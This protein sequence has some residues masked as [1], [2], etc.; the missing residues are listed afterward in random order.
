MSAPQVI[1]HGTLTG[2]TSRK[3]RCELC[4]AASAAWRRNVTR[5]SAYGR[6]Q[7]YVDAEPVR[8]WVRELMAFGIGWRRIANLAG[9]ASSAV[10]YLLYGDSDK[11]YPPARRLRPDTA[12]KLLAVTKTVDNIGRWV[13]AAGSRRRL[14]A[15]ACLGW[16]NKAMSCRVSMTEHALGDICSGRRA[17]VV[18][19]TAQAIARLYDS[20][21]KVMPPETTAMEIRAAQIARRYAAKNGFLPALAWDDDL[22][23]LPDDLLKAE[24]KRRVKSGADPL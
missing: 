1:E 19:G 3:C 13:D 20:L 11:G 15:L 8:I 22:I 2:Y 7:P 14:Q 17:Q 12:R 18:P 21:W 10:S 23:D 24:I 5:Q 16:T 6:W 4:R 9:V